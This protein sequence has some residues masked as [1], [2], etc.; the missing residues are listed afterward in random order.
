MN[1]RQFLRALESCELAPQCFGHREHVRAAFLYLECLPFG[2][3]I[4]RMRGTLQRYT[5]ALGRPEKYHETLTVAF[6]CL[7][8]THR[9]RGTYGNWEE[10]ARLNPELFDSGVLR[11]YYEPATLASPLAR[12]TF[13]LEKRFG[14]GGRVKATHA[15]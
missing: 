9:Q 7:V 6:M 4:D 15:D 10:F 2:A 13:V 8:N 3:A 14:H 11:H 5:A 1:D 12:T